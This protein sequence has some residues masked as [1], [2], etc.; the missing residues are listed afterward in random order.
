MVRARRGL[1][2]CSWYREPPTKKASPLIRSRFC[3]MPPIRDDCNTAICRL[4][5][6]RIEVMSYTALLI[7]VS[8]VGQPCPEM[9]NLN[10][11]LKSPSGL[12]PRYL[13]SSSTA[14]MS[15]MLVGMIATKFVTNTATALWWQ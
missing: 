14:N 5:S 3:K 10:V 4:R 1:K 6:K 2:C 12:S 7:G 13:P 11:M 8:D 9:T 15:T